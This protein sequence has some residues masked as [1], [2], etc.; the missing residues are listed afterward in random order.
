MSKVNYEEA[1][2]YLQRGVRVKELIKTLQALP[3]DCYV[4]VAHET[5]DLNY[6]E[7]QRYYPFTGNIEACNV[8][9]DDWGIRRI[10]TNSGNPQFNVVIL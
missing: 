5:N 9:V 3:E 8:E 7:P 10:H 6:D 1:L 4:V 2:K